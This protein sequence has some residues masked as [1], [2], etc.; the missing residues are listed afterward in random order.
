MPH[1]IPHCV[2]FYK[3]VHS[4]DIVIMPPSNQKI[5]I[6]VLTAVQPSDLIQV[7]LAP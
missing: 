3:R 4:P 1:Q 5:N 7:L 2:L 6:D